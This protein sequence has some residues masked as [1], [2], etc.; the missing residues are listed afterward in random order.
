MI[1]LAL[2]LIKFCPSKVKIKFIVI[3]NKDTFK[4]KNHDGAL[5]LLSYISSQ[6]KLQ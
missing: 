4:P 2:P 1:A 6:K 3:E 5:I